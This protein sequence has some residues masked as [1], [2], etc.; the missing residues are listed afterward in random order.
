[1]VA[2]KTMP[3]ARLSRA[4]TRLVPSAH[5]LLAFA[6]ALAGAACSSA[7]DDDAC[8][9]CTTSNGAGLPHPV[10]AP[11]ACN[12][13][14]ELCGRRYDEV[15]FAGTHGAY[16][17]I[18]EGF[19]APNQTHA[20]ARQL[21][22]GVR[23]LHLEVH[24]FEGDAWT[25]HALC[26]IGKARLAEQLGSVARFVAAHPTEIVT[27]LLER[28]DKQITADRIGAAFE[29]SGLDAAMHR[30]TE[31]QPW[32]TLRELITRGEQVIALLDDTSGSTYDWLLPRW[33]WT[34]ETPW[35]NQTPADFGRCDA[36]RG[37]QGNALYVVD[38]YREDELVPT[39]AAAATVNF[40]PFLLSRLLSCKNETGALPNF[41]MVNFYE[42]GDLFRTVDVLN[43]L[44]PAPVGELPA[45]PPAAWP[46]PGAP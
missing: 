11:L 9:S 26:Q 31:G 22:D 24:W 16:T 37:T 44:E 4:R 25:C 46:D 28:S 27:L 2:S 33:K 13:H 23:V 12:G 30:Q 1:M 10:P 15:A 43:G 21:E 5:T 34:W 39:A 45:F 3:P 17:T 41:A 42:V 38:T 20:I 7:P 29:E 8:A 19:F 18:E 14:A 32:P 40:D 36:D 6:L 35:D